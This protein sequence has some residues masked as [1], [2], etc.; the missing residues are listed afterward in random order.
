MGT[1]ANLIRL[2]DGWKEGE[3]END[4][5]DAIQRALGYFERGLQELR[6]VQTLQMT[7][8]LGLAR[9]MREMQGSLDRLALLLDGGEERELAL[10][11]LRGATKLGVEVE[12]NRGLL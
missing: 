3:P 7:A 9:D 11:L 12:R 6:R 1:V 5:E 4:I 2:D 10:R 8:A